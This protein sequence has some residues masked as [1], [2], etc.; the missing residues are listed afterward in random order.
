MTPASSIWRTRSAAAGAVSPT[1][2][3]SAANEMR[4]FSWSAPRMDQPTA[5]RPFSFPRFIAASR[6]RYLAGERDLS[7]DN[8]DQDRWAIEFDYHAHPLETALATVE[9]VRA[10][11]GPLIRR[12]PDAA[13]QRVHQHKTHGR[14][15][16]E[17]W[18]KTYAVHLHEHARQ[19]EDNVAAWRRRPA[20]ASACGGRAR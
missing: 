2:R 14:Y 11:T 20:P 10:N 4:A 16:A 13:W 15:T 7:L 9:A 3:P 18:L 19:I 17:N 5:S 8:Y 12:L 1:R 6:V